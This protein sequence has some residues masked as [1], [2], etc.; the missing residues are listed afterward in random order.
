MDYQTFKLVTT[1]L[2]VFYQIPNAAD[3][4][5]MTMNPYLMSGSSIS[6]NKPLM[7]FT[8]TD[9]EYSVEDYLNAIT[10]N[11]ILSIKPETVKTPFHQNWIHRHQL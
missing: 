8:G 11:S 10:A 9:H 2:S 4:V 6:S 7:I 3:S 1:Q 5:Q